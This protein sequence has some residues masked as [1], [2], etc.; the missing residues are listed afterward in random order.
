MED[1]DDDVDAESCIRQVSELL[2]AHP[3]LET[4]ADDTDKVLQGTLRLL[5]NLF[6]H[7]H[8]LKPAGAGYNGADLVRHVFNTCLFE[9]PSEE[10]RG[11]I[12]PP[13]CKNED[14]RRFAFT[15]LAEL[16]LNC[17]VN[18]ALVSQLL[19][20]H[21]QHGAAAA[22][23]KST[24]SGYTFYSS[25]N[26]KSSTGFVGLRN[27]GCICYMNA[28]N[29]QFFMVPKFRHSI[30]R[31][32]DASEDKAESVIYQLQRMFAYLQESEQRAYN[33]KPF[34][35]AL[36]DMGEPTNVS[37]Q[38][39]A[40]EYLGNLFQQLE[41]QIQGTKHERLIRNVFGGITSNELIAQGE[42]GTPFY[43]ER[44]EPFSFLSVPVKDV[45]NLEDALKY[46]LLARVLWLPPPHVVRVSRACVCVQAG[47]CW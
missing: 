40:S 27:L 5:T 26:A 36:K 24:S 9:T 22:T 31:F 20:P 10:D 11:G 44:S 1:G 19:L 18:A 32:D 7:R 45:G 12:P 39:D 14:S 41:V 13:Q 23:M 38:K 15:L 29:Q 35:H 8:A 43:S 37:V 21:H 46:G 25:S 30:L 33:P 6:R 16:A 2:L 4:S 28:S 34:T 17:A 42:D 47:D 3:T